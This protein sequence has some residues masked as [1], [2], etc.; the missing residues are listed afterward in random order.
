MFIPKGSKSI[1]EKILRHTTIQTWLQVFNTVLVLGMLI[2]AAIF[3]MQIA[4]NT[5]EHVHAV[6]QQATP[7]RLSA[8]T[9]NVLLT[10][11]NARSISDTARVESEPLLKNGALLL[12][13]AVDVVAGVRDGNVT[14]N[15]TAVHSFVK[16]TTPASVSDNLAKIDLDAAVLQLNTLLRT[17]WSESLGGRWDGTLGVATRAEDLAFAGINAL[18]AVALAQDLIAMRS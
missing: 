16:E 11:A 7:S 1:E 13:S 18:R 12:G 5:K 4:E 6:A 14:V 9:D 8:A 17:N 3:G 15:A 2:T 10:M